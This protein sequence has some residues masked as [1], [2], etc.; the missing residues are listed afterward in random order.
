MTGCFGGDDS[1]DAPDET[2]DDWN[3]HFAAT[4][5]D[6]PTCDDDTNGRLYYVEADNQFQVCKT[7]GWS[8]IDIRG[9]DGQDGAPG[10][11]GADGQDGAPGVD[12][13]DGQDGAPG[14]DGADGVDGQDGANGLDGASGADGQ[15]G[16][17]ILIN[18]KA[19]T[20]ANGGNAFDIG[21]DTNSNGVLGASEV[22]ISV[23]ICNGADGAQGPVGPQGPPGNDGVDG[24]DGVDGADGVDGQDGADGL[25]AIAFMTPESAG[26]NC[27]N[28]GTRIDV[29]VDHNS[30]GVLETSEIDQTQYVCDGGSSNNT[31]LTLI[32]SPPA[33]MGCD[34]GG[35]IVTHGFD[36]GDGGGTYAN[37]VL[38]A[39][40]IDSTT[41]FCSR[42]ATGMVKD[43]NSGSGYGFPSEFIA[44][45]NTLFFKAD[46]GTH[47]FELWKSDGTASGTVMVKNI[48]SGS[49]NSN[50]VH[51]TAVGNIVY[52]SASDATNGEELWKSDGTSS[53]TVMV[54]DINS[55][56]SSSPWYFTAVGNIVYFSASDGTNGYELWKSDGTSSGT[57]MVKDISIGNKSSY[58]IF[59]TTV[60]NTVYFSAIDGDGLGGAWTAWGAEMDVNSSGDEI[61]KSDGTASGTVMVKD[62]MS[63]W[64]HSTPHHLKAVG[65]ALYFVANDGND[66]FQLYTNQAI[67]TEVTYS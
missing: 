14:A 66:G 18:A 62:I 8:I 22:V 65:D 30:N 26:S 45:G 61:W 48:Y 41:T 60:G 46:E 5:A 4:A 59:L 38:E 51:L 10:A 67:H 49:G 6:L 28:G 1:S 34:A 17:S 35:R 52:F 64:D 27:A 54:K 7:S 47:G 43:I 11:D 57:V 40:E 29:G 19:S 21:E 55:S 25:N 36:N 16:T 37:G 32:S 2:L 23:D 42:F 39:G 12:G 58:P 24:Q 44:V 31:R 56:G 53:G 15:D 63:G 9:A 20:C 33:S 13:A 50:P 3:V